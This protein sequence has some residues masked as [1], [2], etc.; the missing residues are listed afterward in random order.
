MSHL[1]EFN[2][3]PILIIPYK[4]LYAENEMFSQAS[5][6]R[7]LTQTQ[8]LPLEPEISNFSQKSSHSFPYLQ[9]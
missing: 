9:S 1:G 7:K 5:I 3:L 2:V 8:T 6:Y 4:C